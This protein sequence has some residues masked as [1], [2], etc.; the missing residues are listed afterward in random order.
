MALILIL[1]TALFLFII[2]STSTT[3]RAEAWLMTCLLLSLFVFISTETLSFFH[4]LNPA[5]IITTWSFALVLVIMWWRQRKYP[6]GNWMLPV[7]GIQRFDKW[8]LGSIAFVVLLTGVVAVVAYPNNWDSMSYHLSRMMHWVQ[9]GS[10]EH[11]AT[12]IDRQVSQPPLAEYIALHFFL[13]S[14][15]DRMCNLVQWIAMCTSVIAVYQILMVQTGRRSTAIAAAF[16]AAFIP[17]GILQAS[18]TQNDYVAAMFLVLAVHY[19]FLVSQNPYKK[20]NILLFLLSVSLGLL[21]KGSIYIFIIPVALWSAFIFIRNFRIIH[22]PTAMAGIL[23][24]LL[25]NMPHFL[26]NQET[27]GDFTG[28][29]KS[30]LNEQFG[31]APALSNLSRNMMMEART[32]FPVVNEWTTQMTVAFH[33]LLGISV[34]DART[35]WEYSTPFEVGLTT[36]HEDYAASP[37]HVLLWIMAMAWMWNRRKEYSRLYVL[38]W[39]VLAMLVL[40]SVLLKWQIWH[41]RLHLPLLVLAAT[42]IGLAVD[43]CKF[44]YKVVVVCILAVSALPMLIFNLSR[45]MVGPDSIFKRYSYHQYFINRD[46]L[47]RPYLNAA[48]II[49]RNGMDLIG[50]AI[51]GDAWEYPLWVILEDELP[52]IRHVL[53]ENPTAVYEYQTFGVPDGIFSNRQIAD[54]TGR[55][56]YRKQRYYLVYENGDWQFFMRA[57]NPLIPLPE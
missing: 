5:G 57:V 24:L 37:F 27:F 34:D 32:P 54:E 44:R 23:G 2:L 22:V 3:G 4:A 49:Q 56:V 16:M 33:R 46:E 11:Y 41:N 6:R 20:I 53:V 17:M 15:V 12:N 8:L 13:I 39:I 19:L 29:D 40:F 28:R 21:T 31:V 26:R 30:L 36:T 48:G 43:N 47:T 52:E 14:G 7:A 35:T 51:S 45:P 25:L 9:Q 38:G 55:F 50:L 10:V 42:L 18:S 1:A